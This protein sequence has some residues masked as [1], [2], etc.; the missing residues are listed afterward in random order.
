[1]CDNA[2]YEAAETL[3]K[4]MIL[5]TVNKNGVKLRLTQNSR[6]H[7]DL[8]DYIG[9]IQNGENIESIAIE[10]KIS[11][12]VLGLNRV[13]PLL[14]SAMNTGIKNVILISNNTVT[15]QAQKTISAFSQKSDINFQFLGKKELNAWF[16]SRKEEPP[17]INS[18]PVQTIIKDMSRQLAKRIALHPK[19]F[20]DIEWRDLERLIATV[21]SDFGYNVELTPASKDGGKDVIVWY[22][23][24]SYII[25]IKHWNG[26]KVGDRYISDFLNVIIKENRKSGLYLSSS[27]YTVNAFEILSKIERT[28]FRYGDRLSMQT[29]LKMYER[30]NNGIY[31]PVNN[32]EQIINKISYSVK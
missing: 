22:R 16:D 3:L 5:N 25:E 27:G 15:T 4:D 19:E 18:T 14:I 6:S 30:L 31:I 7:D 28:K 12:S 26:K 2:D 24:E 32:L 9:Q 29:L 17:F 20:M 11:K 10:L 1:M 8:F 21:F 23:G 13:S